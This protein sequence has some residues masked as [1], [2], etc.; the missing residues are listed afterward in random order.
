MLEV[1]PYLIIMCELTFNDHLHWSSISI[2]IKIVLLW[3]DDSLT[4][5]LLVVRS[6]DF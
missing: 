3:D 1:W 6:K 2:G 4:N 5:Q